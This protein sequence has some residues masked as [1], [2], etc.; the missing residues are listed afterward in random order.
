M[1]HR[2]RHTT[3]TTPPAC[4]PP[5]YG[6][7]SRAMPIGP[8]ILHVI[9]ARP[10][11]IDRAQHIVLR[12]LSLSRARRIAL[13]TSSYLISETPVAVF[14]MASAD[15]ASPSSLR[16]AR[17]TSSHILLASRRT[18]GPRCSL[19]TSR[20]PTPRDPLHTGHG[21]QGA[22][23]H[24]HSAACSLATFLWPLFSSHAHRTQN[25][26]CHHRKTSHHCSCAAHCTAHPEHEPCAAHCAAHFLL[27]DHR[28]ARG[29]F[30]HGQC[31]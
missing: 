6:H 13:H 22:P 25:S 28:D 3:C 7:C 21:A 26:A 19:V 2:V 20:P 27:L 8:S 1:A 29:D 23:H 30:Q 31:G 18:C 11:T 10:R 24:R 5:S 12:T 17:L 4:W 9:I 14:N 15:E 16:S